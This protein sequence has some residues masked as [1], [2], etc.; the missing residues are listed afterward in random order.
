MNVGKVGKMDRKI[1][2]GAQDILK[3]LSVAR[4]GLGVAVIGRSGFLSISGAAEPH[5]TTAA[6]TIKTAAASDAASGAACRASE[7]TCHPKRQAK[8]KYKKPHGR[9]CATGRVKDL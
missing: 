7:P 8:A 6:R 5:S 1:V 4:R 2:L 9:P 3:E